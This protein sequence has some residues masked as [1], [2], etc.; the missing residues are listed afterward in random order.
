MIAI[1]F[2]NSGRTKQEIMKLLD[3]NLTPEK[4]F[5]QILI[6]RGIFNNQSK[7]NKEIMTRAYKILLRNIQSYII[8]NEEERTRAILDGLLTSNL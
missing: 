6:Q 1:T 2:I 7:C 8:L 5:D 3:L 4:F